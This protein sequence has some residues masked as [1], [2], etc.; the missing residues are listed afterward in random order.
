MRIGIQARELA[1]DGG[2]NVYFERVLDGLVERIDSHELFIFYNT[3][4]ELS[5]GKG[6]VHYVQY[7]T[8]HPLLADHVTLPRKIRQYDIDR[9]WFPKGVL[10]A[11]CPAESVL[12]VH[13]LGYFVDSSFYPLAD[14]LYMKQMMKRS[15]EK[16]DRI[17]AISQSTKEDILRYT[18][19]NA[20]AIEVVYHGVDSIFTESWSKSQ[21]QSLRDEL[22]LDAETIIYGAN[23][24][25]RKN[26]RRLLEAFRE[27][28][29]DDSLL[30]FTGPINADI[31]DELASDPRVRHL[32]TIPRQQLPGLYQLSTVLVYPSLYEGFGLPVLEAMAS[33]TPVIS[34][35]VS[36]LPEVVGDAGIL[37]EPYDTEQ[38]T[39][40]IERVLSN[41]ALR[42][43]LVNRGSS[44]VSSFGWEQTVAQTSNIISRI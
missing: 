8:E 16:A 21:L 26:W 20:N 11:Y 7:G 15:C 13:D 23:V 5:S 2:T 44:R 10:P 29:M 37:V 14:R 31:G 18:D 34:S 38:L 32:G 41:P 6:N 3:D 1:G 28:D 24:S 17:I 19:A 33:G 35:N 12:T 40:A 30:V 25:E 39:G 43:R 36:S 9:V 4:Q 42:T 27:L 22:G